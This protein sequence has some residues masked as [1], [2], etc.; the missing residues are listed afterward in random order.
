MTKKIIS[1]IIITALF[2]LD[3]LALHDIIKNNQPNYWAEYVM[4][5]ISVT[6]F[7]TITFF[8]FKKTKS[9]N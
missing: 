1:I 4:L 2:I 7:I 3:W 9:I 8:W 6:V 5:I